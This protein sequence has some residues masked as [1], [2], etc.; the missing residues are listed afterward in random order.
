MLERDIKKVNLPDSYRVI[1]IAD[2]HGN[3]TALKRLLSKINYDKEKDYL[4][5]LGDLLE[6][7]KDEEVL[8]INYLYELSKND[9][10]FMISGNNDRRMGF[11][12]SED[13]KQILDW[14]NGRPGNILTQWTKTIGIDEV[15]EQNY[16]KVIEKIKQK[17]QDKID[18]I[19][20]LPLVIE[21]DEFICVHS[22]LE[23]REDWQETSQ[24]NAWTGDINE[25]NKT[26][27][28]II[29][30]HTPT[31]LFPET[32]FTY[33]PIIR[34]ANKTISIDGG[35]N[36]FGDGQLNALI[37]EKSSKS[38]DIVFSYDWADKFL[39]GIINQNITGEYKH[40]INCC[41]G[42]VKYEVLKK[43]QYFTECRVIETG[44]TGLIKN[45][46]LNG[47][48]FEYW[49]PME[50]F[51]TVYEN[52]IVSVINNSCEGYAYIRNSKSELGWIPKESLSMI[53]N[54]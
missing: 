4:F 51:A 53:N 21:T 26:G 15:T 37:I 20:N 17:H 38:E 39:Q 47:D 3:I 33:L 35:S 25:P 45:E 50:N 46:Y 44:K 8:T 9:R 48:I 22:A 16:K 40:E 32:K 54:E 5:I 43:E 42:T 29:S 36:L 13:I 52:E 1:C 6:R 28:W 24:N 2:I 7:G 49:N 14:I 30:G 19:L 41:N 27:R 31:K 12:Q 18:F 11:I 23:S 34:H 10:V